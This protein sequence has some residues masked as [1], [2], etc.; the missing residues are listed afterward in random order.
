MA[1]LAI[2]SALTCRTRPAWSYR[3]VGVYEPSLCSNH[4]ST[5]RP[6]APRCGEDSSRAA[7]RSASRLVPRTVS[8]T[9]IARPSPSGPVKTR[10]CQTPGAR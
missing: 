4:A 2:G 6:A 8:A 7:S 9:C 5:V 10:T 3:L 1:T